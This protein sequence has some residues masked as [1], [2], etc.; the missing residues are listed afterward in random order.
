MSDSPPGTSDYTAWEGGLGICCAGFPAITQTRAMKQCGREKPTADPGESTFISHGLQLR[1][2]IKDRHQAVSSSKGR[3]L[4]WFSCMMQVP[5]TLPLGLTDVLHP[6]RVHP[7]V[8]FPADATFSPAG[9]PFSPCHL[10][11][12][13]QPSA[14]IRIDIHRRMARVRVR[15]EDNL[16][17]GVLRNPGIPGVEAGPSFLAGAPRSPEGRRKPPEAVL[18]ARSRR[19]SAAGHTGRAAGPRCIPMPTLHHNSYRLHH[20]REVVV[21][22]SGGS[23]LPSSRLRWLP[24]ILLRLRVRRP[25]RQGLA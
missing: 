12:R 5:P 14:L 2:K 15:R 1:S 23:G 8:L 25:W 13:K 10:G 6:R 17:A 22:P 11:I 9:T 16:G 19:T 24:C 18:G 4:P 21:T 20:Q 7:Q 3:Q